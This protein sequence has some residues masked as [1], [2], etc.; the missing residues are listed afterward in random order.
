M[1]SKANKS[2]GSL[3]STTAKNSLQVGLI[4][5]YDSSVSLEGENTAKYIGLSLAS[6]G[7]AAKVYVIGVDIHSRVSKNR[8]NENDTAAIRADGVV[9]RKNELGHERYEETKEIKALQDCSLWI[10]CIET[11]CAS[12]ALALIQKRY[13]RTLP[14]LSHS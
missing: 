4:H 11:E 12:T 1:T 5:Q 2:S 7:F 6:T 8:S 13:D 9:V 14:P 10:L 3:P